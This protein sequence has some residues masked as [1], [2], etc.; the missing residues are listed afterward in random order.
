[1]FTLVGRYEYSSEA[2][3]VKAK[4]ESEGVESFFRDLNTVDNNPLYSNLLGGIKLFVRTEDLEKANDVL[5]QISKYSLDDD[6]ELIKCPKCGENQVKMET[7]EPSLKTFINVVIL[8][9]FAM[10]F[11]KH[12]YKCQECNFEFDKP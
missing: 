9:F 12:K 7:P 2:H 5:N 4:L 3:I 11:E 1:M 8:G 10:F 6:H